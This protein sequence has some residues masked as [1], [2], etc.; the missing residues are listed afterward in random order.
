M[1]KR[2]KN[3][4]EET[5]LAYKRDCLADHYLPN[6]DLVKLHALGSDLGA[7]AHFRFVCLISS[8]EK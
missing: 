1:N 7:D 3:E 6:S 5:S 2:I 8:S 4:A